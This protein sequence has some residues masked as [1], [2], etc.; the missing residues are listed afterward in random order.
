MWLWI[1]V[2]VRQP[3]AAMWQWSYRMKMHANYSFQVVLL[4]GL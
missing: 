4:M 1:Y 3:M 2:V